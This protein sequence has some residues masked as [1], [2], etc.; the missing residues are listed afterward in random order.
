MRFLVMDRSN[1]KL[2]GIFALGDPVFN[3]KCRDEMIGWNVEERRSRLVNVMDAY[4]VGAVPPYNQLLGGKLVASLMCSKEVHDLFTERYKDTTGII[5]QQKKAPRLVL[6]T[7]T[8]ALGRSSLYNR[9]RLVQNDEELFNF[10]KIG[11]TRG[12]GHFQVSNELFERLR[13]L[14]ALEGHTYANGHQYGDGP[15]W[16]LRVTRVGLK[17]L[18]LDDELV[19]HGIKREVYACAFT[20]NFKE[21][22][23]GTSDNP[24]F[25]LHSVEVISKAAI[26]RWV[27]PRSSSQT[28][29]KEF[30]NLQLLELFQEMAE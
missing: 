29:W 2:I 23:R 1:R 10:K 8:S 26:Q 27:L 16:K 14:L 3:L 17:R 22:L 12:F 6:I 28:T 21:F 19:H 11:E 30:S 15:N 7:V 18:G 5:S 25:D 13:S 20:S 4:V 9:L 24:N